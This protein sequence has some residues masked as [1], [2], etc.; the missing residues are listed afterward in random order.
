MPAAVLK[1]SSPPAAANVSPIEDAAP[2][3][4]RCVI[5]S[6]DLH[7]AGGC[8]VAQFAGVV[9]IAEV[10]TGPR[11]RVAAPNRDAEAKS[12]AAQAC[13]AGSKCSVVVS[14]ALPIA[15][16]CR[17]HDRGVY[18]SATDG[19]AHDAPESAV[20]GGRAGGKGRLIRGCSP[21]GGCRAASAAAGGAW[22]GRR[23]RAVVSAVK[24]CWRQA[25]A[26]GRAAAGSRICVAWNAVAR[27]RGGSWQGPHCRAGRCG[28][29]VATA[30]AT[31]ESPSC[32]RPS[33]RSAR[34]PLQ[35]A[36]HGG[37]AAH[38]SRSL[39]PRRVARD[40]NVN[41]RLRSSRSMT[42]RL[43]RAAGRCRATTRWRAVPR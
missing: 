40:R 42:Q 14:F 33:R 32:P 37:H 22:Y 11:R 21:N 39:P 20:E 26:A 18:A 9:A 24:S 36:R 6:L 7:A 1:A 3:W 15:A 8:G 27:S 10:V 41:S 16:D 13:T 25:D 29:R 2:S 12:V 17:R 35:T 31:S 38:S 4:M 28:C 30:M 19:G 5:R 43:G 34:A 23:E